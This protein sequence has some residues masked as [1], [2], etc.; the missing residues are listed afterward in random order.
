MGSYVLRKLAQ[1]APT[2]LGIV[3][4]V[5]LMVRALP[6]DP[7]SFIAGEN[8]GAEALESVREALG[9]NEP[10]ASQYVDFVGG[11]LRGDVGRSLLSSVPV[12][13][14]LGEALPVTLILAIAA[15]VLGM[16]IAVPLG[17]LAAYLSSKGR[18]ALDHIVT[19][20]AMVVDVMPSF[21]MA[22][23]F[24][25]LFTLQLGWLPA[26]GPVE[27]GDPLAVARRLALPVMVLGLAQ[28]ATVARIVRTSVLE[29]LD[30]NYIRTARA[31]GTPAHRVLFH[32]ALKNAALPV[33]TVAGLSFGRLLGGTVIVEAVFALPGVGSLLVNGINSRD[34]P[35]V[36]GVVLVYAAV[37]ITVNLVTDLLY[38]RIDP[39]V[40]L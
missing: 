25:L 23:I 16:V 3:T 38:R 22:L 34:Y 33:I 1:L 28:V 30:E 39:R 7:A 8:V 11:L 4:L 21:W 9:L 37:F 19:S 17:T 40:T 36:Q 27:L 18:N 31:T 5:F 14:L 15:L 29:V 6:G 20:G 35:I 2:V 32:H 24:M 13:T 10:L 12:S 26:T